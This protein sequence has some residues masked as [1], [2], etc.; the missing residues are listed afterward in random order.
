MGIQL[1]LNPASHVYYQGWG[2][3]CSQASIVKYTWALSTTDNSARPVEITFDLTDSN[4]PLIVGIDFLRFANTYNRADPRV[5][6]FQRPDED[7]ARIMDTYILKDHTGNDRLRLEISPN[8]IGRH[9]ALLA[10]TKPSDV[11][12]HAAKIHSFSHAHPDDIRAILK[13]SGL[14][15]RDSS[16]ACDEA[17][18]S[19]IVCTSTGRPA[20]HCKVSLTHVNSAFNEEIQADFVMVYIGGTKHEVLNINDAGTRYGERTIAS[21]RSAESIK[22]MMEVSWLYRHGAPKRFSA[23]PEFCRP[24]LQRFMTQHGITVLPRPSRSSHKNGRVERNNGVFK[25]IV[26]RIAKS[27][28]T[29]SALTIVARSSFLTNC[30]RGS[31][32]LSAFQLVRGYRPSVSGIPSRVVSS[33]MVDAYISHE[34]TRAI[35]RAMSSRKPSEISSHALPA[36]TEVLVFFK[37]SAQNEPVRWVRA[38]VTGT[39]DHEVICRRSDKGAPMRV[40]YGDVRLLPTGTLAQEMAEVDAVDNDGDD[41]AEDDAV[42]ALMATATGKPGKD[43]GDAY[44]DDGVQPQGDLQTDELNVLKRIKDT[45]GTAQVTRRR[46]EGVPSWIMQKALM[47]EHD[48]NWKDAYIEMSDS[49]VDKTENVIASHVVYKLKVDEAGGMRLKARICPHGNRDIMKD[50]VRKDSSTAQ[51]DVIRT[52]L[53]V[54]TTMD[55]VLGHVDIK[56][57]YLQSGPIQRT[58]Y[59]RPPREL[60]SKKGTLW[61]LTKLPY[62]ITEAGRQWAMVFEEW[63]MVE[64]GVKRVRGID[65]LYVRHGDDGALSLVIAKVTDDLLMIGERPELES[66]VAALGKRFPISKTIIDMPIKFNGC[67]IEREP[68]GDITMSMKDYAADISYIQINRDRRKQAEESTTDNEYSSFKSL[69]GSIMWLGAGTSPQAS[70]VASYLQQRTAELRVKHLVEANRL[71]KQLKS[72]P[73]ALRYRKGDAEAKREVYTF[74]DA[75][76]NIAAGLEYGQTGVI[77]A[78]AV[79]DG[80]RTAFHIIDWLSQKQRRIS[81]SSYGAEILACADGD[82]RGF[83]AKTSFNELHTEGG[84]RH[85][86]HVDSKGLFDTIT[87]LHNGR[88]YR[89]RQTVQRIRDSFEARETDVIRWVQSRANIA[90]ALTKWAPESNKTLSAIICSGSLTL[91]EHES[92]EHNA[93]TWT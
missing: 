43:V 69:A 83:H 17:V 13:D 76:F 53:S 36:G 39:T 26:E 14:L 84:I 71:L 85:V 30:I 86:L 28:P 16:R 61:K 57:A 56:G 38:K 22:S 12:N 78:L 55:A 37:T 4:A 62:G 80:Q 48:D 11:I 25:L 32:L 54:A 50:E 46:M 33:E 8:S 67:R 51:Y 77:V 42:G 89:L 18:A 68:D 49:D 93:E 58:I 1:E 74:A 73:T 27:D 9:R 64:A 23:D 66:F 87:T 63:L 7:T 3:D 10:A 45:I 2:Q 35:N 79:P 31:K 59:V 6:E 75:S 88:E 52:A 60:G 40:A 29:A 91:P 44:A 82:D 21:S 65:Q 19:C 5:I 34:A 47:A 92:K 24:V 41:A 90:D 70:F 20:Q 81:H 72:L 15:T